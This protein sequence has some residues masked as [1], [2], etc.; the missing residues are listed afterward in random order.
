MD[1]KVFIYFI[2]YTQWE[3]ENVPKKILIF[4]IK[5]IKILPRK[6][7][8]KYVFLDKFIVEKLCVTDK[9]YGREFFGKVVELVVLNLWTKIYFISLMQIHFLRN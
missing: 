1:G 3:V 8:E 9:K 4:A 5:Q 7:K 6:R 2:N